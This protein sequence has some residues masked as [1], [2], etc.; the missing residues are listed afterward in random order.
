MLNTLL[1]KDNFPE[2]IFLLLFLGRAGA[3]MCFSKT[4]PDKGVGHAFKL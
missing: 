2:T 4:L 1:L 3:P